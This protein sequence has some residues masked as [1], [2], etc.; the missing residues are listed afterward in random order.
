MTIIPKKPPS[1]SGEA[2]VGSRVTVGGRS[3]GRG[4]AVAGDEIGK[5][6]GCE[7]VGIVDEPDRVRRVARRRAENTRFALG[8]RFEEGLARRA[9]HAIDREEGVLAVEIVEIAVAVVPGPVS[10]VEPRLHRRL[11]RRIVRSL[12]GSVDLETAPT[13][14][15][16]VHVGGNDRLRG[17]RQVT[18][19]AGVGVSVGTGARFAGRA[20]AV[21]L[22]CGSGRARGRR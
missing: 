19:V 21:G 7:P 20:R 4:V 11:V 5:V 6:V 8:G 10:L 22:R 16:S 9:V 14:K 15:G 18:E 3:I 12:E 1:K 2:V 13:A 17:S